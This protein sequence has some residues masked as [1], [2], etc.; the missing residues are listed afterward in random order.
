MTHIYGV[1]F[2]Q[3]GRG[4]PFNLESRNDGNDDDDNYLLNLL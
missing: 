3:L 1:T 4:F 2:G